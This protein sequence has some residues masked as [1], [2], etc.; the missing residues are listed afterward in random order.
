MTKKNLNF[1]RLGD[2]IKKVGLSRSQIYSL[3][4]RGEFP[5]QI[6]ISARAVAWEMSQVEEWMKNRMEQKIHFN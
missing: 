1:L 5:H 3:I 6:N 4:Q 2:L